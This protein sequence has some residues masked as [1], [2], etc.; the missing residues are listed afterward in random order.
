MKIMRTQFH[1]AIAQRG[2]PRGF[3]MESGEREMQA[4]RWA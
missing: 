1:R 2:K 4:V 3:H